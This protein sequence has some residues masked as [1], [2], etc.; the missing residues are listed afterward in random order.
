MSLLPLKMNPGFFF[1]FEI[2]IWL[3]QVLVAA[4]KVFDRGTPTLV[5]A[6]RLTCPCSRLGLSSPTRDR[7]HV[8]LIARQILNHWTTKEVPLQFLKTNIEC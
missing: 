5:M 8:P 6:C 1:F 7:T 2:F 4:G 3:H